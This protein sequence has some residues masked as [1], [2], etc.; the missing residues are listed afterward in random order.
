MRSSTTSWN[1]ALFGRGKGTVLADKRDLSGRAAALYQVLRRPQPAP[2]PLWRRLMD[3]V[4]GA[5][6]PA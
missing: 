1:R 3:R 6:R 4:L 2:A 5:K